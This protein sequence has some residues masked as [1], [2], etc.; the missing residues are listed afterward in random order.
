MTIYPQKSYAPTLEELEAL[1]EAPLP[2]CRCVTYYVPVGAE[3]LKEFM[4]QLY[5]KLVDNP[6]ESR[7]DN[8]VDNPDNP[9]CDWCQEKHW[10]DGASEEH[11]LAPLEQSREESQ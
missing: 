2:Q 6:R 7:C 4:P 9:V 8:R 1:R 3:A 10:K 11:Q 5:Q